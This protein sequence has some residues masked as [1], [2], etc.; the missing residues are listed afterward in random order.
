MVAS[1]ESA[2]SRKGALIL[3]IDDDPTNLKVLQEIVQAMG[4]SFLAASSGEEG[5]K[6]LHRAAPKIILLDITM[7]GMDGFE[8][9]R[10]I[11]SDFPML[12]VPVIFVSSLNSPEDVARGIGANGNDYIIKPFEP[13]KLRQRITHWLRSGI[14]LGDDI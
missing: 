6:L 2:T 12:K 3:G 10:R 8:T 1:T 11:R 5:L 9:C 14:S 7:P 13:E 4:H